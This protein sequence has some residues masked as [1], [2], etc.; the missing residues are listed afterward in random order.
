M[1][2]PE[3]VTFT[4]TPSNI[5]IAQ[6]RRRRASEGTNKCWSQSEML[7]FNS[8]VKPVITSKVEV[9]N[10]LNTYR[11]KVETV[12]R[13]RR[14]APERPKVFDFNRF[15]AIRFALTKFHLFCTW[16]NLAVIINFFLGYITIM[17]TFD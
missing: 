6:F 7:Q 9:N 3:S 8:T 12:Y 5:C 10:N 2:V 1:N 13:G 17:H 11:L 16:S 4:F 14:N 15:Q